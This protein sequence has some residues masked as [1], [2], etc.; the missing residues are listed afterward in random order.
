MRNLSC[1]PERN[2]R[3]FFLVS[4][5][6]DGDFIDGSRYE[7]LPMIFDTFRNEIVDYLPC[8]C[9]SL[10]FFLFSFVI[11]PRNALLIFFFVEMK[12]LRD[13]RLLIS[14]RGNE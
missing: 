2:K 8:R 1:Q 14:F 7:I 6:S 12:Y 3:F 10:I 9:D 5:S 11:F 13:L 4:T